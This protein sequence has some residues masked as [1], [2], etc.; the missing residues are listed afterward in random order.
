MSIYSATSGPEIS[1][2][3]IAAAK[4]A[5]NHVGGGV[6]SLIHRLYCG[7]VHKEDWS[8]DDRRMVKDTDVFL[9]GG[10]IGSSGYTGLMLP[11]IA[12]RHLTN[13]DAE[14]GKKVVIAAPQMESAYAGAFGA[15][16]LAVPDDIKARVADTARTAYRRGKVPVIPLVDVGGTK[17]S[18]VLAHLGR[19]GYLTLTILQSHRFAT[20]IS[21]PDV[22]YPR[23]GSLLAAPLQELASS[24]LF[25]IVPVLAVGHPGRFDSPKGAIG[26]GTAKDLGAAFPGC[27]P[28]ER[29]AQALRQH[30]GDI[31]IYLAND[32]R[33]QFLGI[34]MVT[35]Q[36]KPEAWMKLHGSKVAYLGLG[37]G[38]GAGFGRIDGEG[39]IVP[40]SM[41][42]AFDIKATDPREAVASSPF[43]RQPVV[44][45][46]Y[47]YGDLLSGKY[48]RRYMH[49]VDL[50]RLD[51]GK[52]RLFLPHSSAGH[53]PDEQA[54][55]LLSENDR[56]S[57]L[58]AELLNEI[59][60]NEVTTARTEEIVERRR[61]MLE[62]TLLQTLDT[63]AGELEHT[64]L[65]NV[66]RCD[67]DKVI[68]EVARAKRRE[69][70]V[71]FLGIGKSHAIGRNLAYVYNNLGIDTSSCELTGANCENLRNLREDDLVFLISNSGRAA[72]VLQ[73]LPFIH[74]KGCRTVALTGDAKSPLAERC[75]YFVNT[76][77]T[78]NPHP[79]PEAPTT[80][81][82]SALAAATA[83]G[84]VVSFLFDYTAE[85]F[86]LDHPGL[87]FVVDF[88]PG[89]VRAD[90]SFDRLSKVEDI[91]RRFAA[92]IHGLRD[93]PANEFA[94]SMIGLTKRILVSHYN[95]R[96]VFFTGTGSSL[97]VA[98][99][100]AATLTSIGIDASCQNSA[101]L[102]HG[103]FAHLHRGDLLV[104]ISFSGETRHLLEIREVA[105]R[106]H[107][108][109]A[110]ITARRDS[111]LARSRPEFLLIAGAD[112]DDTDLVAVPDQ[113]ILSSF[114]NLTVG[115]AL[116]V[117]LGH[118][119][120]TT[121]KEFA[122]HAHAG[123]EIARAQTRLDEELLASL[124]E[125]LVDRYTSEPAR[126]AAVNERMSMPVGV[127]HLRSY[128]HR[129]NRASD[130]MI[131]GM[132]GIGLAY[133]APIFNELHRKIWFVETNPERVRAMEEVDF[134]Y[135]V[136]SVGNGVSTPAEHLIGGVSVIAGADRE[137]VTA[138]ALR[139]DT[140][141][142]AVGVSQI[143]SL[144]ETIADIVRVRYQFRVEAP[145]NIV[146]SENFP[147]GDD[148]LARFRHTLRE[149]LQSPEV[150]VYFDGCVGLV[151][152]IDEAVVPEI[153]PDSLRRPLL[154][155]ADSAVFYIDRRHWCYSSRR[156]DAA[157]AMD[158][159]P[160]VV[161][162]RAF[163]PLHMRKLW[164]H[165]M[166]HALIGYLGYAAGYERM[167]DAVSDPHI[168]QIAAKAMLASG[169][170]LYR[171]W[172][173][174]ES[175]QPTLQQY[176][177]WRLDR[178]RNEL[179]G[180][181][182]LRVCRDP[183]RKLQRDDRLVGAA[184]YV[185]QYGGRTA[186][187]DAAIVEI[188]MG[189]VGALRYASASPAIVAEL[190]R[191]VLADLV[192][193]DS[194]LLNR[195]EDRFQELFEAS[196][197]SRRAQ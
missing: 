72:E 52:P 106:K 43:T 10:S 124:S 181:T 48:F 116:A 177:D 114:V 174:A 80:S 71:H 39:Q 113:K 197:R 131:F 7:E 133:L 36:R 91:L 142:T 84:M 38:L 51:A 93:D 170:E 196:P 109:C 14:L 186:E 145:L 135:R 126:L 95:G 123:G 176:L 92:A 31:D 149:S 182:V 69:R 189:V 172:S 11:L 163:L 103:D 102:P 100:I 151:P 24:E 188:L 87:E 154:I 82:T 137:S 118:I 144:L 53:L 46:P 25:E 134:R 168:R 13:L 97:R 2:D 161:L 16:Q 132:G 178:Y 57:P 194:A 34:G 79:I 75:T 35:R 62:S 107:V 85:Q 67:Y 110:V 5:V 105:R 45:L 173:Y 120:G 40:F 55:I 169:H 66:R 78:K 12:Q 153:G 18:L 155:E 146:F 47:P 139:V 138:H 9:L 73:L 117:I 74:R 8:D 81:T 4:E 94:T 19:D 159:G 86:H 104:L 136:R 1:G 191:K 143:P 3:T 77:V 167:Y 6:A 42:N 83:V 101:Q 26:A 157:S 150:Q 88:P 180:D 20:P 22:F 17:V 60:R 183:L 90:A 89:G 125:Q 147:V 111:Q 29:L 50:V 162:T 140:I 115:D 49:Q 129:S 195:A 56:L 37:T 179:L 164:V 44:A 59:L 27:V 54:R 61:E 130:V 193:I 171:R 127:K 112:A 108:D 160:R 156:A 32:G 76:H 64:L 175:P 70:H 187:A 15:Y 98:E 128:V 190:R 68:E 41:H 121:S 119:L 28:S 165:N 166:G 184:N 99:K 96:T 148:P 33:C 21:D 30:I 122:E 63:I 192:G 185:R 152:G 58:S 158:F 23:L 65:P 141:V